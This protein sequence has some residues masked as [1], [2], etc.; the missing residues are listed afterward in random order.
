[1]T[2]PRAGLRNRPKKWVERIVIS[3]TK[4]I[5]QTCL[6][7]HVDFLEGSGARSPLFVL[8]VICPSAAPGIVT[9]ITVGDRSRERPLT[10]ASRIPK[11]VLSAGGAASRLPVLPQ[12]TRP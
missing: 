10:A 11:P 8:V 4:T 6:V 1:M 9:G 3:G 5:Q 7:G 2:G 12:R